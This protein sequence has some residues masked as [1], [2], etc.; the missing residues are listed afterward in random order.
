MKKT[1]LFPECTLLEMEIESL[2]TA[3]SG[4]GIES[5]DNDGDNPNIGG[6]S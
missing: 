3:V 5:Y 1:Y 2:M 4:G 6:W